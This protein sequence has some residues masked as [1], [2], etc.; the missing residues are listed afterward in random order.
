MTLSTNLEKKL[1]FLYDFLKRQGRLAVAYSGGVDSVFLVKAACIALSP[2]NVLA[3]TV[4]A[5]NFTADEFVMAGT[6]AREWGVRQI[7]LPWDPL[8]VSEF[9]AN[10]PERCYFCK[11]ALFGLLFDRALAMGFS[12]LADGANL[13]DETDYRPGQ[14]AARELGVLSPL[15]EAGFTKDEVHASLRDYG[16]PGWDR[17]ANACLASRVPCGESIDAAI[18]A[19]IAASE[20]F[21]RY[22]G[23]LSVRVR[24]HGQVALVE[25]SQSDREKFIAANLWQD[26]ERHL[27]GQGYRFAAL[28]LGGYKKGNLNT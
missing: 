8:T 18:L 14:R 22:R 3:L 19:R 21:F 24:S 27:L 23:L 17:P 16:V 1:A 7:I 13:D 10:G 11:K 25:M 5:V 15:R 26:A 6:L 4:D 12:T 2:E 28:D 9:V 20:A